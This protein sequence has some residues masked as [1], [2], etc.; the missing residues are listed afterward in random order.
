MSD[1]PEFDISNPEA[2]AGKR[3]TVKAKA[4][5]RRE[6]VATVLSTASGRRFVWALLGKCRVFELSYAQGDPT[7]TAFNEGARQVGNPL[8]AEIMTE[9]AEAYALMAAESKEPA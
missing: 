1:H 2:V 7:H 8:L 4:M 5:T 6:D 9:H 3:R